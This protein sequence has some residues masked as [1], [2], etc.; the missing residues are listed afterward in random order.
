MLASVL[1]LTFYL[2]GYA[3]VFCYKKIPQAVNLQIVYF[4][5]AMPYYNVHIAIIIAIIY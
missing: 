4:M 2:S 1:F 5:H 3:G